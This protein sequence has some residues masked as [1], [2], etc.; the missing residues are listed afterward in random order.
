MKIKNQQRKLN[1]HYRA[2]FR[3]NFYHKKALP[4]IFLTEDNSRNGSS[5]MED[6]FSEKKKENL[7]IEYNI[8]R[9]LVNLHFSQRC[10][11]R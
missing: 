7:E 8:V 3:I 4:S 2:R 10:N 9:F 11:T 6:K 5:N 1:K